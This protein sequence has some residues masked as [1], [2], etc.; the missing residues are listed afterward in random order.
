MSPAKLNLG[1]WVLKRRF[2]GYHEIFT[3]YHKVS[4]FDFIYIRKG[5][6]LVETSLRIPMEKNLVYKALMLMSKELGFLPEFEVYIEKNIPVGS[7]LGGGSSNVASVLNCVNDLLGKPLERSQLLKI[8]SAV[9][10]D[11]PFFFFGSSAIGEGRGD[12]IRE[13]QLPKMTFTIICPNLQASSLRVYS[14]LRPEWLTKIPDSNTIIDCLRKGE[15]N[16]LYNALERPACELYPEV[17][18]VLR[19]LRALGIEAQLSGSGAC[20]YYAGEPLEKLRII[21]SLRGWRIY[22][23]ESYGV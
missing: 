2:D 21:C 15:L 4:L 18:E 9:S 12:I 3:L 20:V 11:A 1:L 5:R 8:A 16:R 13:I 22:R 6:F 10:S 23:V 17:G 14:A 7:G 19:Y